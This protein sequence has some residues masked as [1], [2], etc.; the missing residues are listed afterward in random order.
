[1]FGLQLETRILILFNGYS[2]E[3]GPLSSAG[4]GPVKTPNLVAQISQ[5]CGKTP[6]DLLR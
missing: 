3:I 4:G 5:G 1:M 6:I 2:P